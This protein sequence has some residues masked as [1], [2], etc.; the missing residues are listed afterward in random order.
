MKGFH[1][2]TPVFGIVHTYKDGKLRPKTIFNHIVLL[3]IEYSQSI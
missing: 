2:C 1:C 3:S